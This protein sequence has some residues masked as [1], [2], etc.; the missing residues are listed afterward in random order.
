MSEPT[1]GL[2]LVRSGETQEPRS[3]FQQWLDGSKERLGVAGSPA[4]DLLTAL[5]QMEL[6]EPLQK[7]LAE[8][9]EPF[10]VGLEPAVAKDRYGKS[11]RSYTRAVGKGIDLALLQIPESIVAD[12]NNVGLVA[13]I[14]HAFEGR[15]VRIF[16]PGAD[17]GDRGLREMLRDWKG[18]HDIDAHF[19]PSRD[20]RDLEDGTYGADKILEVEDKLKR[21]ADADAGAAPAAPAAADRGRVFISYSS[22]DKDWLNRLMEQLQPLL[23][24]DAFSVWN[25][26]KIPKG[27]KWGDEIEQELEAATAA[28]LL[29]S[30]S[31]LASNFVHE[32]ELPPL[33]ER[34]EKEKDFPILWVYLSASNFEGTPIS[35][36]EAAHKPLVPLDGL[37]LPEQNRVLKEVSQAIKRVVTG[38]DD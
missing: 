29:V 4:A 36:Y 20:V 28:V 18:L 32:M 33:V 9:L 19:V 21:I 22:K 13:T 7:T 15:T 5:L 25:D 3:R 35:G 17:A 14:G 27:R 26:Q 2:K 24:E 6:A 12:G 38:E 37:S 10:G 23:R 30:P 8:N 34:A 1:T 16:S 11:E 31:F